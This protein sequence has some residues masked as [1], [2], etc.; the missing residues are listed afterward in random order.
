MACSVQHWVK[1]LVL[2]CLSSLHTE[3]RLSDTVQ[4]SQL[5]ENILVSLGLISLF[6]ASSYI[7]P[8]MMVQNMNYYSK[9][10]AMV[11]QWGNTRPK[12]KKKTNIQQGKLQI[13]SFHIWCQRAL[14]TLPFQPCLLQHNFI[15]WAGSTPYCSS[16]WKISHGSG[17]S[18]ILKSSQ[19]HPMASQGLLPSQALHVVP[20]LFHTLPDLSDSP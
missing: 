17:M 10:G 19:L 1:L 13:L 20:I 8:T 5:G 12:K 6:L 11:A 9:R 4:A 16:S 2:F 14:M 18:N 3:I 15:I 7:F